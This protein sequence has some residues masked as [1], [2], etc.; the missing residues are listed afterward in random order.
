LRERANAEVDAAVR[1]L[2]RQSEARNPLGG[3]AEDHIQRTPVR[4]VGQ[5]SDIDAACALLIS[6]DASYITG[7]ILGVNGG[8]NT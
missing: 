6:D 1:A 3:T 7:Q 4:R 5:P 8:R 2:L